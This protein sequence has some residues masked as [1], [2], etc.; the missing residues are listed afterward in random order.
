MITAMLAVYLS[1]MAQTGSPG[2][3]DSPIGNWRGMSVCQ[4]KPSGC[5][6]EDS[7]Y[8]FKAIAGKPDEFELQADKIVDGKPITMG[9][10]PCSYNA[11]GQLA[12]PIAESG[13]ILIFE[14]KGNEMSGTMTLANGTL[15]RKLTLKK[16][17]D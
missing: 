17:R 9:T 7:L 11:K 2:K 5:N 12:C 16:V 1:A 8:H 13:A 3:P 15:W 4:V 10:G 6:D 14:V